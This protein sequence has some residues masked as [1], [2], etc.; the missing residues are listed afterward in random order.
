[1][2]MSM[3]DTERGQGS[4][5]QHRRQLATNSLAA[6]AAGASALATTNDDN[7]DDDDADA[8]AGLLVRHV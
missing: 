6:A 5:R 4:T 1:M 2:T 3:M 7:D 8:D